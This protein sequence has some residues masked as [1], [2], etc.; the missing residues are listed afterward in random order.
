MKITFTDEVAIGPRYAIMP[1]EVL[2]AAARL[3]N[4]SA[5]RKLIVRDQ[6]SRI[7]ALQ[8]AL[9]W[10]YR[11]E[12]VNALSQAPGPFASTRLRETYTLLSTVLA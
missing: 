2:E 9:R 7:V 3:G 4:E 5:H 8:S 1:T 11:V 6:R 10:A 12:R